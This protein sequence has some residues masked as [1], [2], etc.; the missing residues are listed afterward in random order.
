MQM[1]RK[2]KVALV[3]GASSG[4]GEA[5]ARH[6]AARGAH[7]MLGARRTDRLEKLVADI[8]AAGGSAE[9]SRFD[10]TRLEN[11]QRFVAHANTR[12]GRV[13]VIINNAGVMPLSMLEALKIDE[14]NKMIDVNSAVCCTALQPVSR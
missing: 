7:V 9:F 10:V 3:T 12:F 4:I 1:E 8:R 14:W 6:L 13:D 2:G 11:M 5:A